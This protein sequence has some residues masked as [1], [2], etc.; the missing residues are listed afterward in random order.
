MFRAASF[1]MP[2]FSIRRLWLRPLQ[3]SML[4]LALLLVAAPVQAQTRQDV[5]VKAAYLYRFL[6]YVDWP[7]RVLPGDETPLVVGV[8]GNDALYAEFAALVAGRRMNN[9]PIRALRMESPDPL[10]GM[11]VLFIGQAGDLARTIERVGH[12]PVLLVSDLPQS[13]E[14][15]GMLSLVPANGRIRFE[16]SP[17]AAERS[18]LRLSSRLLALADRVVTK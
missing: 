6:G 3:W 10:E 18:G 11:H 15:G 9:H 17:A 12:R 8:L 4:S 13:L 5:A 7:P 2:L 14:V 1:M 16:A